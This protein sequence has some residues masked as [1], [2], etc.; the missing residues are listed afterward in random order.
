MKEVWLQS[1]G[2]KI[3]VLSWATYLVSVGNNINS[4]WSPVA[5]PTIS[6][7]LM[8]DVKG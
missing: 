6:C 4:R 3:M 7:T 5:L 2:L 8:I 1:F